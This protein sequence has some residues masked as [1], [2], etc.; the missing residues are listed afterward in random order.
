MTGKPRPD[1]VSR[2]SDKAA[3]W[4][5]LYTDVIGLGT[6]LW[7]CASRAG[8]WDIVNGLPSPHVTGGG[9]GQDAVSVSV[10]HPQFPSDGRLSS[11]AAG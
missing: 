4:S 3:R 10:A 11:A 2:A 5:Q 1:D 7:L 9:G 8:L 6:R